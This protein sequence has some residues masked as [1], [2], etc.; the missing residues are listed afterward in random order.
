MGEPRG[1]R[2]Y[3]LDVKGKLYWPLVKNLKAK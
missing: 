3:I 1:H 2:S